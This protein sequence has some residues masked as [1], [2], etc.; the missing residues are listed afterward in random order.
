VCGVFPKLDDEIDLKK[1]N[2][3]VFFV[4]TTGSRVLSFGSKVLLEFGVV[5]DWGKDFKKMAFLG[6]VRVAA[7][8][9]SEIF[10]A[11]RCRASDHKEVFVGGL[12]RFHCGG[13]KP[14]P[15]YH[16]HH[17]HHHHATINS[18]S[19][20]GQGLKRAW[21]GNSR[22]QQQ[23]VAMNALK[24]FKETDQVRIPCSNPNLCVFLHNCLQYFW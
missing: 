23:G 3:F 24:S 22:I 13:V 8:T 20:E 5:T 17:H 1:N 7:W 4:D 11:F 10:S 16:H 14:A 19:G 12:T 9:D 6:G 2:G 15:V 21:C 18:F